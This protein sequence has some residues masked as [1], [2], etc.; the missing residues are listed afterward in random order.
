MV[1]ILLLF[2][3]IYG[4]FGLL[5]PYLPA[6]LAGR[7]LGAKTI[8]LAQERLSKAGFFRDCYDLIHCNNFHKN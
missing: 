5:S 4:G 1:P 8:G 2:G 6:L 7:E 3:L